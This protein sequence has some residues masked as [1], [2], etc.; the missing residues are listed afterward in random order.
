MATPKIGTGWPSVVHSATNRQKPNT[1]VGMAWNVRGANKVGAEMPCVG[2]EFVATPQ[3]GRKNGAAR[4][5]NGTLK[6]QAD[7]LGELQ[8]LR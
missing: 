2:V 5:R 7:A 3:A 1:G 6:Y 8:Y 4:F